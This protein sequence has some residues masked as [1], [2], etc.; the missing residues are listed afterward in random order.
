VAVRKVL[1]AA[2]VQGS[3][4]MSGFEFEVSG[5]DGVV[6]GRVTTVADGRTPAIAAVAGTYTVREVARPPWA[7]VLGDGGPVTFT[8]D[9]AG[10]TDVREIPYTNTVPDPSITTAAR[11]LADGDRVVEF[12]RGDAT[13]VDVVTYADLVPGTSYVARGELMV[14][15]TG[16]DESVDMIATGLTGSTAFM[17]AGPDGSIEVE[18]SIP[19]ESPLVGHTVVVYQQ[20]AV[21]SSGR[22]VA[23]HADPNAASQTIRLASP[24]P[25]TTTTTTSTSTTPIQ[26]PTTTTTTS[27]T[28]TS[29][30][31]TPTTTSAPPALAHT[32]SGG[33]GALGIIALGAMGLGVAFVCSAR[34]PARTRR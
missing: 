16:G 30:T 21:A 31:T 22:V 32:G 26:T 17:P 12:H 8:F 10:P 7:T 11:D 1:D 29:P 33:P 19:A 25:P 5:P 6:I 14:R 3:R 4:D 15:P 13:I 20:L 24:P 2:D 23:V 28:T 9:P 27:P 18:F 34:R